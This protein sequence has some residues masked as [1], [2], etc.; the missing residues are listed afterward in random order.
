VLARALAG[1]VV[2]LAGVRVEVEADIADGLPGFHI[3]GLGDR[4]LQEARERVKIAI[5][6]SGF[7]FP[8]RKVTVNLAPAQ[9][10][11]EGTGF[12]LA[13]A[14]AIIS[15]ERLRELPADVAWLGE[16]ALDG[17]IRP[18]RGT[19]PIAAQLERLG[20]RRFYVPWANVT[21]ARIATIAPIVGIRH[22]GELKA[23]FDGDSLPDQQAVVTSP[24]APPAASSVDLADVHG[25][26]H[27]KRALEIAAA[28]AHHLLL[29]GPPGAGKTLLAR[30][31]PGILPPLTAVEAVE[32]T[33]IA[34]CVGAL[35][36]GAGLLETPPF[37]APH[38]TTSPAALVGGGGAAPRPGEV[39][40]AHRGVLFLDEI[41]EFRRDALESL[42]QPL[43]EGRLALARS[44]GHAIL[45]G[46]FIL[47]AA[48][49]PCP[50]GFVGDPRRLCECTPPQRQRYRAR[51]SGPIR[52][53]IDLQVTVPR[54]PAAALLQPDTGE[55]T[56]S[57]VRGR[58]LQARGRQ[59][60]RRPQGPLN[61][62]LSG[63]QLRRDAPLDAAS[64][65]L[66]ETAAERLQLSG[67]AVHRVLRVAR[68]V[69][70]LDAQPQ[71]NEA[72]VAEALQYRE[73]G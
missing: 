22:L 49:N 63:P 20:V 64:Q 13:I 11:K 16:L 18:I 69:A 71:I 32:V 41:S 31:L 23:F 9:L 29:V 33:S 62:A 19:L 56:S 72:H 73:S 10:P 2:G 40:R 14:A 51:L 8:G 35:P 39:T 65:S 15:A 27:A 6:N 53:R 67:R 30:A 42:R 1:T 38:H 3:V 66:L 61:G 58:V 45:P 24:P 46:R 21:E 5:N 4:A 48:S 52:D 44:R 47:V 50:C 70:D 26:P 60:E 7:G 25:Q 17:T 68:T 36:P 37:R 54:Q 55:T 34:S 12:D 43:E 57:A 28:G 59:A